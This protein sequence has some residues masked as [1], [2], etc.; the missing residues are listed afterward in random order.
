MNSTT[1]I[2]PECGGDDIQLSHGGY[3]GAVYHCRNCQYTGPLVI[4]AEAEPDPAAE[5]AERIATTEIRNLF[6]KLGFFSGLAFM[7]IGLL[8]G[9]SPARFDAQFVASFGVALFALGLFLVSVIGLLWLASSFR[10]EKGPGKDTDRPS[11]DHTEK[12]Q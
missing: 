7:A 4:D 9:L 6:N 5:E 3:M 1:R 8:V 10:V 12:E 2:C 11:E